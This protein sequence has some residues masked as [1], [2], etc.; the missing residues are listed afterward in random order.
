M[1]KVKI[2]N[3]V[4]K[5][6][7]IY[8]EGDNFEIGECHTA[9]AAFAA[10]KIVGYI[11]QKNIVNDEGEILAF[12]KQPLKYKDAL[13]IALSDIK[14]IKV[15]PQKT[16]IDF[17]VLDKDFLSLDLVDYLQGLIILGI[18]TKARIVSIETVKIG[19]EYHEVFAVLWERKFEDN[20]PVELIQTVLFRKYL[21]FVNVMYTE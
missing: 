13:D 9:N 21:E 16:E 4:K 14:E 20:V 6:G 19:E 17:W 3:V 11:P 5:N 15:Y 12:A 2:E 7:P 8:K 1:I 10:M 18:E